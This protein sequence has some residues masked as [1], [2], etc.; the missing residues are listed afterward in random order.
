MSEHA[1]GARPLSSSPASTLRL[2]FQ[3]HGSAVSSSAEVQP[4]LPCFVLIAAV[5]FR[6][7]RE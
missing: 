6:Y 2:Y 4:L 3:L 7:Q 1:C 5:P